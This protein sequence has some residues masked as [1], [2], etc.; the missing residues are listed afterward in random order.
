MREHAKTPPDIL[1]AR[2]N[3]LPN[4]LLDVQ[5]ELNLKNNQRLFFDD[6]NI[7][8]KEVAEKRRFIAE[9]KKNYKEKGDFAVFLESA[10][11]QAAENFWFG[12]NVYVGIYTGEPAEYNDAKGTDL[13]MEK[14]KATF[15]ERQKNPSALKIDATKTSDLDEVRDKIKSTLRELEAGA[16]TETFF[17]SPIDRGFK[18]IIKNAP[19]V[20]FHLSE[21][22]IT[23]LGYLIKGSLEEEKARMEQSGKTKKKPADE[24]KTEKE[25]KA[26]NKPKEKTKTE[27]LGENPLQ[28]NLI[29]QGKIQLE[30][31]VLYALGLF[32]EKVDQLAF[33][34]QLTRDQ[35]RDLTDL[36]IK[37]KALNNEE[38]FKNQSRGIIILVKETLANKNFNNNLP[39]FSETAGQLENILPWLEYFE[40][41]WQEKSDPSQ[42][43]EQVAPNEP[44]Q[45]LTSRLP[46]NILT[47]PDRL[48]LSA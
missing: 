2:E 48:H 46:R 34:L 35:V 1:A 11:P 23:E 36:F 19:R 20:I 33:R 7:G 3:P 13:I 45:I 26:K 31:Q 8:A 27:K 17:E 15:A 39:R 25:D 18:T 29:A 5:R 43:S 38:P 37:A 40:K 21:D 14:A 6:F 47:F 30:N 42:N 32:L 12:D 16:F 10:I 24:T 44:Q 9:R 41:L 22:Q 28:L 4:D